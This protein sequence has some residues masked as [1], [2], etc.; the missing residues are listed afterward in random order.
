M[1][2]SF[3]PVS[4]G[5]LALDSGVILQPLV[6]IRA[7]G[8]VLFAVAKNCEVTQGEFRLKLAPDLLC[9]FAVGANAFRLAA[10][11]AVHEHVPFAAA[12]SD[13]NKLLWNNTSR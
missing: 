2:Q 1:D 3:V 7:E 11:M 12:L 13:L 5:S 8:L 9:N 6:R 10:S 4:G